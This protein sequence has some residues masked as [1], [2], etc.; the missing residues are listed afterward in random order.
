LIGQ[1]A[2][3]LKAQLAAGGSVLPLGGAP[4]LP[5]SPPQPAKPISGFALMARVLWNALRRLLTG[6]A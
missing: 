4:T 6:R 3:N 5:A 2:D 1:F